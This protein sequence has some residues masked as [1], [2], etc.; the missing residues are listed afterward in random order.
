MNVKHIL[1]EIEKVDPEVYERMDTRRNAMKQ[2]QALPA[3]LALAS[4]PIALGG[5]FKKAYGQTTTDITG[6]IKLCVNLGIPGSKI[7]LMGNAAYRGLNSFRRGKHGY[8]KIGAHETA[9]V[10]FL[11]NAIT[12][13][14]GTPV[15]EPTF[16]FTAEVVAGLLLTYLLIIIIPC[17]CANI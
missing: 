13:S 14:G 4:Y 3:N 11:K 17:R 5:M 12:D 9:H 8:S 10:N 1:N 2:F 6:Y 16:D 15:T 7:L